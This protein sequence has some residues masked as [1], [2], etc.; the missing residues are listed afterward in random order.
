[1]R[2]VSLLGAA[3]VVALLAFLAPAVAD[4]DETVAGRIVGAA[5]VDPGAYDR[6][7]Y[8]TDRI[9]PRLSGSDNLDA[10]IRWAAAE[11]R[12][13]GL[14]D[15]HTEP[16]RVPHWVRGEERGAILAPAAHPLVLTTLGGSVAT[17][18]GGI[19]ADVVAVPGFEE[20]ERLGDAVRGKMVLFDRPIVRNG[21]A[22]HGYGSAV[23][24]RVH[25][26]SHAAKQ[27]AVAV[28]VRSLGTA[29]YRLPHTGVMSYDDGAPKVPGV[30]ITA[31]DADLV[32]RLLA[33]GATVRV[34]LE[35]GARTLPDAD[36]ANVVADLRGRE[37]PDEIVV[38]GCHL[39]S[40]DVGTG[41]IDDG[42]GCAIVMQAVATLKRL[43]LRPRRTIRAVLYTNEENGTRGGK[44]YAEAHAGEIERHVAAIESD[45]GAGT[46][47]GF[48]VTAGD[49]GVEAV[50]ALAGRLLGIGAADVRSGGGGTD[51]SPLRKAGVPSLSLRQD[52]TYYFDWHHTD[53]DTLDKVDP[54]DLARNVAA[55]AWMAWSLAERD[56]PLPRPAAGE[57]DGE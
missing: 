3:L 14:D 8:L 5:L 15:V 31:E 47:L 29:S 45:S 26:A 17:P 13:D 48:G 54:E 28:L 34:H 7:A 39:D 19:T 37:R 18:P 32:E 41:A 57:G 16:V 50:R 56:A 1:M 49:G 24:L 33:T 55:M 12:A 2:M 22:E 21:G 38:I 23:E 42:A 35:V 4:D 6:L 52:T 25:G 51:I 27:G 10:A 46:P 30:A 40:W 53:A 20:L 43:G 36:S 11:L 44:G 9:G